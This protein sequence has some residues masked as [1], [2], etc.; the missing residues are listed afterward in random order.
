M[1]EYVQLCFTVGIFVLL[2]PVAIDYLKFKF[3]INK[4][5][6]FLTNKMSELKL[7]S[8]QTSKTSTNTDLLTLIA[9]SGESKSTLGRNIQ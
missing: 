7:P 2:L 6:K 9:A 4:N 5:Y 8:L 1:I 3:A